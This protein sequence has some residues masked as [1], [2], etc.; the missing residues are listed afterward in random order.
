MPQM[1]PPEAPTLRE[2]EAAG[3]ISD[4][5]VDQQLLGESTGG[6]SLPDIRLLDVT[7]PNVPLPDVPLPDVSLPEVHPD[8]LVSEEW[9]SPRNAEEVYVRVRVGFLSC[10]FPVL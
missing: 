3:S 2:A 7:P 4:G 6:D 5:D 9:T 10:E 8:G 1:P